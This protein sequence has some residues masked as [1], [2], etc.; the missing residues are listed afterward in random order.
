VLGLCCFDASLKDISYVATTASKV[1]ALSKSSGKIYVIPTNEDASQS[2]N[3]VQSSRWWWWSSLSASD[4]VELAPESPLQRGEKSVVL[5]PPVRSTDNPLRFQ[6]I[7]AGRDHLLALTS[8]GRT[9][10]LPLSLNANSHGQLG[11]RTAILTSSASGTVT[12]NLDPVSEADPFSQSTPFKRMAKDDEG[13]LV[14]VPIRNDA[15]ELRPINSQPSMSS[16]LEETSPRFS[17]TLKEIPSLQGLRVAQIATG[18]RTSYARTG[19]RVLAWG[20][21][22]HGFVFASFS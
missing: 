4:V 9:F 20:A 16:I 2:T 11:V 17:T 22:E 6:S 7:A 13:Q 18:G 10:S 14:F 8:N 3:T 5:I 12:Q 1:I 15:N 21:N 19:G